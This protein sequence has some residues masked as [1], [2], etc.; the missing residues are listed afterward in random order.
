MHGC[1]FVVDA[2]VVFVVVFLG[3][4]PDG[5]ALD[6]P[7]L[8]RVPRFVC[9]GLHGAFIVNLGDLGFEREALCGGLTE[10]DSTYRLVGLVV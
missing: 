10:A 4:K 9:A 6:D 8:H 1:L 3:N 2:A 7:A 5:R